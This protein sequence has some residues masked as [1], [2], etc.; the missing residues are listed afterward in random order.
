MMNQSRPCY[1][2][3]QSVHDRKNEE[4]VLER[5]LKIVVDLVDESV[6]V[7]T[8]ITD[9]TREIDAV[10][11]GSCHAGWKSPVWGFCRHPPQDPPL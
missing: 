3:R 10:L 2:E 9:S 11:H 8:G 1:G 7:D 6:I 4:D 5:C